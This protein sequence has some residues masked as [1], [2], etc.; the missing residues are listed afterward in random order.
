M[1]L[2]I[3][4][5]AI[6]FIRMDITPPVIII[7]VTIWTLIATAVIAGFYYRRTKRDSRKS[8]GRIKEDQ[9]KKF[10]LA[11]HRDNHKD[12]GGD[13]EYMF[14][15]KGNANSV[16]LGAEGNAAGTSKV[17]GHAEDGI[18]PRKADTN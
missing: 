13:A 7:F 18:N 17:D 5:E 6:S 14:D 12:K 10:N 9:Q 3:E 8:E 15:E 1:S 4:S 16:A 2:L 11:A